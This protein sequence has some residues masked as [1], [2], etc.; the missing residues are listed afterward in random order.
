MESC[1]SLWQ[2]ATVNFNGD[3]I[4]CCSEFS[5]KDAIGNLLEEPFRKIWN[6]EKYKNLRRQNKGTLNCQA[7]HIDKETQ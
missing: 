5:R 7:C 1:Y 4:P 2:V 6:N 3:V